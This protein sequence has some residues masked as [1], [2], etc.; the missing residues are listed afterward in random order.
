MSPSDALSTGSGS[1][2]TARH[3]PEAGGR[4]PM[5]AVIIVAL[6]ISAAFG[7][8]LVALGNN[9]ARTGAGAAQPLFWSGLVLIFAPI[10]LRQ[11]SRS[12]P[13]SERLILVCLL[14]IALFFVKV[15]YS[16]TG[17]DFYDEFG[18]WRATHDLLQSG[19]PF[20][21][22]PLVITT[23]GFPGLD[24]FTAPLSQLGQLSIFDSGT[25]VVGFVRTMLF[26]A[27]FLFFERAARSTRAAGIAVVI[28]ACNPSFLYFNAQFAYESVALLLGITLLL[29]TIRW[30]DSDGLDRAGVRSLAIAIVLTA[31][32]LAVTHHMTSYG[33]FGLL[34]LWAVL[35]LLQ[36]KHLP[37]IRTPMLPAIALGIA[38][39]AWFTFVAG[40]VTVS[41]LGGVLGGAAR[42]FFDLLV[43]GS[44]PKKPFEAGG[45]TNS[46][47][48][49]SI[50]V[51]SVLCLAA[52]IPI[53]IK[54]T[55]RWPRYD[56]LQLTLS[57][58]AIAYL[59]T[60]ALR[61]TANGTE[62]SQRASEFV[63]IGLAY[64]AA[65]VVA[66]IRR[67]PGSR[68]LALVTACLGTVVFLGGF[69]IGEPPQGRQPGPFLVSAERRSVSAQGLA[70]ARFAAEHLPPGSRILVDHS[71]AM[72]MGSYGG[73]DPVTQKVGNTP[74][75][76]VFTDRTFDAPARRVLT[77]GRIRYIVVDRRLARSAPVAGYYFTSEEPNA[78][79]ITEGISYQALSK[80]NGVPGL[81]KIY[82]NGAISIYDT[83]GLTR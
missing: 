30:S 8:L 76:R 22:N 27:L 5:P 39:S 78:Y 28:Y 81:T 73:L 65:M 68:G 15:L 80:F 10:A 44:G 32:T 70:A 12:A 69:I 6:A 14:S 57:L 83:S 21:A 82:A 46:L 56:P 54:K 23:G 67:I 45:Q 17:F 25:L 55:W 64:L 60:L 3:F 4:R 41:E 49:R 11:L 58:I 16:P 50:A 24:L 52:V 20:S 31:T 59:G 13:R 36:D 37:L 40:G 38:A 19:H 42:S 72:L 77:L 79:D 61:L 1:H 9:A 51:V 75:S 2:P 71:N 47:L 26:V 34:L 29:L 74:I 53:G 66:G 63:F 33:M 7:V 43:G 48:A 35:T 62:T 18:W